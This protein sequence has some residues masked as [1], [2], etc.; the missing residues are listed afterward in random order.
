MP[1]SNR[2]GYLHRREGPLV[3]D[4]ENGVRSHA[5]HFSFL[6]FFATI[7][8]ICPVGQFR[9]A[10]LA[11]VGIGMECRYMSTF[12]IRNSNSGPNKPKLY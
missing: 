4:L 11:V 12:N 1:R 10:L 9:L 8:R 5:H 3:T 6:L 7:M 2:R